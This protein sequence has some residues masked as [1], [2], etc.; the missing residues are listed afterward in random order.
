MS[1][2]KTRPDHKP[3]AEKPYFIYDPMDSE[4]YYF[5]TEEDRDKYSQ[6]IIELFLDDRWSEE[7]EN[8]IAGKVT[9]KAAQT[10]R[11][12]RPADSDLDE[13]NYTKDGDYW[14]EDMDYRCGYSLDRL[15]PSE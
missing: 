14:P 4:F 15:T 11:E 1:E 6:Q 13:E 3:S 9:H 5:A 2:E 8:L 7:V 10:N 12:D